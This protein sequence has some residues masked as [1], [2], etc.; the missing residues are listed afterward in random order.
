MAKNIK[1]VSHNTLAKINMS[2]L[3]W[4]TTLAYVGLYQE[5]VQRVI[6]VCNNWNGG[7]K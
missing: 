1:L 4:Q 6:N 7:P 5:E 3:V 2:E